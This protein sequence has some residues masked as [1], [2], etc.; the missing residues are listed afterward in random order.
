MRTPNFEDRLRHGKQ[1]RK[2]SV[3]TNGGAFCLRCGA[4]KTAFR[5][6]HDLD[7]W[8]A[9]LSYPEISM[10]LGGYLR[11][12]SDLLARMPDEERRRSENYRRRT[13]LRLR[14]AGV[15]L[16]DPGL[17]EFAEKAS[18]PFEDDAYTVA[19]RLAVA[20][21]YRDRAR[22]AASGGVQGL[23]DQLSR[24]ELDAALTE[25]QEQETAEGLSQRTV[26]HQT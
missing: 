1:V 7:A 20:R 11:A 6:V 5:P 19:C 4:F 9:P 21:W 13:W 17:P 12:D 2:V 22:P 10:A 15:A 23:F 24:R 16:P 3:Y 26:N 18:K 8:R 25:L 14:R